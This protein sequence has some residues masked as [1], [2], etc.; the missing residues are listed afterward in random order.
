MITR[1]KARQLRE[2]KHG[3]SNVNIKETL[4]KPKVKIVP[5]KEKAEKKNA[6]DAPIFIL[7]TSLNKN[8]QLFSY[9]HS[10]SEPT[11]ALT[12]PQVQTLLSE[13]FYRGEMCG[14]PFGRCDF[15][16][17]QFFE[18]AL[19]ACTIFIFS[20]DRSAI[21]SFIMAR[22]IE[23]NVM[24]VELICARK[25]VDRAPHPVSGTGFPYSGRTLMSLAVDYAKTA[26]FGEVRMG[27]LAEVMFT[28]LG[29]DLGFHFR[30]SCRSK[31]IPVPNPLQH[32]MYVP[33]C[34]EE[35]C[36]ASNTAYRAPIFLD[37]NKRYLDFL[38]VLRREGLEEPH[39]IPSVE[40]KCGDTHLSGSEIEKNG[41]I[42]DGYTM[43]RCLVD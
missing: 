21:R 38:R 28:Y 4:K 34:K 39:T 8:S 18:S 29:W 1:Q 36:A 27:A 6:N 37:E 22:R 23:G 11:P 10:N 30:K 24:Y 20:A 16:S 33:E 17:P 14:K 9:A 7:D 2:T 32:K 12:V 26:G 3:V 13:A 40:L 19:H 42:I 25:R 35:G 15:I 43:R 5:K 41:C 31:A